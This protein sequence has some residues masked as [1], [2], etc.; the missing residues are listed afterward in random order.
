MQCAS[1]QDKMPALLDGD[2][3]H[4][5]RL[6]VSAHLAT[7]SECR[8]ALEDVRRIHEAARRACRH[9]EPVASLPRLRAGMRAEAA[10]RASRR[11]FEGLTLRRAAGAGLAAAGIAVMGG[12]ALPVLDGAPEHAPAPR[13]ET[14]APSDGQRLAPEPEGGPMVDRLRQFERYSDW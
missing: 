11:C 2:C 4:T 8:A 5:E 12:L 14:A 7:C 13:A 1:A 3:R 10:R 9:P 6:A